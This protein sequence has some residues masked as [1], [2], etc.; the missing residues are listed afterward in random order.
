MAVHK[1]VKTSERL[2]PLAINSSVRFSAAKR[3][4]ACD[5]VVVFDPCLDKDPACC[6]A[7]AAALSCISSSG[8]RGD[9]GELFMSI[10]NRTSQAP[11]W[12]T[13]MPNARAV[14]TVS[15]H[16]ESCERIQPLSTDEFDSSAVVIGPR[17]PAMLSTA[18]AVAR[19]STFLTSSIAY[20]TLRSHIL[21]ELLV[22]PETASSQQSKTARTCSEGSR[23]G[24]MQLENATCDRVRNRPQT[25]ERD[26]RGRH[27]CETGEIVV[28]GDHLCQNGRADAV[29]AHA[30]RQLDAAAFTKA[31]HPMVDRGPDRA[32]VHILV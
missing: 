9:P 13:A 28:I 11:S 15:I 12:Q 4:S 29:D 30:A 2:A 25:G 31:L 1:S 21:V 32:T 20:E 22:E 27:G 26:F 24:F 14:P 10:G 16:L 8:L 18:R 7:P 17:E 5:G 3:D 19:H 23:S 6:D